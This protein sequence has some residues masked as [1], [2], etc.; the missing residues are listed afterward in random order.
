MGTMTGSS[1]EG[2]GRL[3][4]EKK[5]TASGVIVIV[6]AVGGA[7][8]VRAQPGGPVLTW[9]A[10]AGGILLL[11]A[12]V[13]QL[14][15]SLRCH[16]KGAIARTPFGKTV[17]RYADVAR[18]TYEV[19]R[20]YQTGIYTGT[21]TTLRLEA[22]HPKGALEFSR[23]TASENDAELESVRDEIASEVASR[24]FDRLLRGAPF[25]WTPDVKILRKGLLVRQRSAFLGQR[26]GDVLLPFDQPMSLKFDKGYLH[27][28]QQ[29]ERIELRCGAVNFYPGFMLLQNVMARRQ[30]PVPSA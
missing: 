8:F 12:G 30:D 27:I 23:R 14:L 15:A 13:L 4:F 6:V 20:H 5:D 3:L 28:Q 26:V 21:E 17:M 7:A 18:F 25:A 9:L 11:G 24:H 1:A 29:G 2:L 10:A 19:V 22:D 16:E